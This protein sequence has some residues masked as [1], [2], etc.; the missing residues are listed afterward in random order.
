M[1]VLSVLNAPAVRA[2]LPLVAG[3]FQIAQEFLHGDAHV[4]I[5]GD[6]EQNALLDLYPSTWKVDKWSGIVASDEMVDS[7]GDRLGTYPFGF[8]E[9]YIA[10]VADDA[11][12]TTDPV[13]QGGAPDE[14]RAITFSA[15]AAPAGDDAK[16]NR[17]FE[18]NLEPNQENLF[19]GGAWDSAT[20]GTLHADA[21]VYANPNGLA[22]G[23]QFDI[24]TDSDVQLASTTFSAQSNTGG[25]IDI[26]LSFSS[27][28]LDSTHV[29][30]SFKMLGAPRRLQDQIWSLPARAFGMASPDSNSRASPMVAKGFLISSMG[31]MNI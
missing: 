22:S 13:A 16:S 29:S 11:A 1:A 10:T 18:M 19:P 3:N 26:P 8:D 21:I 2:D 14:M 27:T 15:Q 30:A 4:M 7:N 24:H 6:S 31:S 9:P 23:L 20:N 12:D 25:L 5:L 17:I 28:G